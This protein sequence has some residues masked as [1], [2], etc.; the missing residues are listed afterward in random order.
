MLLEADKVYEL[1]IKNYDEAILSND[2]IVNIYGSESSTPP[3]NS[4][5]M[6]L[7]EE[8]TNVQPGI[9]AMEILPKYILVDADCDIRAR[10][11]TDLDEIYEEVV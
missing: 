7:N 4:S 2:T 1:K 5:E 9:G 6:T 3:A 11:L 10:N 8:N